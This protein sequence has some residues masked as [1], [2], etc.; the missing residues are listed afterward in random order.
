[1]NDIIDDL[2]QES[3]PLISC[4]CVTHNKPTML[5]RVIECFMN[6]SYRNKQLVIV[7]EELDNLTVQFI[8]NTQFTDNVKLV[9]IDLTKA[10]LSLGDLRNISIKE[11]DGDY[12][13]Q[14]DDDDWYDPDRLIIQMTYLINSKKRACVLSRWVVFNSYTNKA[15]LSNIRL[16]EGSLL[17]EKAALLDISYPAISKGED[18]FIIEYLY[19]NDMLCI[20]EDEAHIYIYNYH[21]GNTWESQHF[22]QI[23]RFS[24]ELP[25][26]YSLEIMQILNS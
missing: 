21:G 20:I 12:I 22:E 2:N 11:S 24:I 13:C 18:S 15:Y 9:K 23:F 10:K 7:Y 4:L 16:W 25:L 19:Q 3:I 26:E 5:E 17:C 8:N 6:Q 1:M 14:W